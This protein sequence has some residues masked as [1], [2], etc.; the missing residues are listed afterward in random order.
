MRSGRR[1]DDW[2]PVRPFAALLAAA[3]LLLAPVAVGFGFDDVA[4]IAALRAGTWLLGGWV[5]VSRPSGVGF[6]VP[7]NH[8][9]LAGGRAHAAVHQ[10]HAG[11]SG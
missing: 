2:R 11:H 4:K 10:L 3:T 8:G 5:V 6:R 9:L 1:P 7:F